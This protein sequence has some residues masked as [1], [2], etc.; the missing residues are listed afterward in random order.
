MRKA[1]SVAQLV[2]EHRKVEKSALFTLEVMVKRILKSRQTGARSFK[3]EDNTWSFYDKDGLPLYAGKRAYK[4]VANLMEQVGFYITGFMANPL[5]VDLVE[6]D[7][8]IVRTD[9]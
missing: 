4:P 1:K 9:W 5:R 2:A 8:L 6:G 3:M 7:T